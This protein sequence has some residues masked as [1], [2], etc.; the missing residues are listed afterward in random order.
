M[1][2]FITTFDII[3]GGS[4]TRN[5]GGLGTY[6]RKI[7][8][9]KAAGLLSNVVINK[10]TAGFTT[11]RPCFFSAVKAAETSR[12]LGNLL[13]NDIERRDKQGYSGFY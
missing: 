11:E 1:A 4:R 5:L 13:Q 12:S 9:V 3:F 7:P 6:G 8:L 10:A 2:L